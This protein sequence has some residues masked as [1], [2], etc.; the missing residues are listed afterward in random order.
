MKA[1][2]RFLYVLLFL[3]ATALAATIYFMFFANPAQKLEAKATLG[4]PA[5][6]YTYAR[7]L[8]SG[9]GVAED[10]ALAVAWFRRAAEGGDVKAALTMSRLYFTGDGVDRD[11]IRGAYWM[12]KAAEAGDSY[13]AGMM[14]MLYLGGIGLQ[15]DAHQALAW[16]RKS[17]ESEAQ[18][19]GNAVAADLEKID[20]AP[21]DERAQKLA[22]F[23]AQKQIFVQDVFARLMRRMKQ[24]ENKGEQ[25][26]GN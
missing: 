25:S 22:N 20:G 10:D 14:G 17:E 18:A 23:H 11:M 12:Q 6:Q 24:H 9:E 3:T 4:D 7:K 8:A 21:E 13:A 26:D 5:A 16:F 1:I 15:Q 2:I 19:L